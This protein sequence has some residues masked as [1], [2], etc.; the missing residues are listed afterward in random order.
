[1]VASGAGLLGGITTEE[2]LSAIRTPADGLQPVIRYVLGAPGKRLRSALLYGASRL[3]DTAPALRPNVVRAASLVELLHN[4]TL[5]H[6]DV[7]DHARVRRNLPSV[8]WLWG[9]AVAILAGDFL[10][11]A[12]TDLA[13]RTGIPS[14]LT[15]A[16]E[17]LIELVEGQML[18][19]R[20]QGNLDLEE[21]RYVEIIRKKTASLMSASCRLGGIVTRGGRTEIAALERF[22]LHLGLAF[23]ALDDL[24]DYTAPTAV[25]G[26]E[27]GK[28]LAEA[29][30]TLPVLAALRRATPSSRERLC[31]IF[32][33]AG[34][35][36][37]LE[38][39]RDLLSRLGGFS[40]TARKARQWIHRALRSLCAFPPSVA[41]QDLERIATALLES[42]RQG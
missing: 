3:I 28:D 16:V 13:V 35:E 29:K 31:Q 22:G 34:R 8:N 9:D 21:G 27:T 37:C 17:T 20:N 25:S 40:Y 1:M 33:H 5:L 2:I 10:L 39:V 36:R 12:V 18:E 11:A 23:Q 41:R 24:R 4:G 38:E 42:A 15:T 7:M 14:V 19:I 30:V 6:D 32:S 26:K